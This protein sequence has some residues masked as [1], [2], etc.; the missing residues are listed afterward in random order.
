MRTTSSSPVPLP[1]RLFVAAVAVCGGAAI[2]RSAVVLLWG[3]VPIEWVLFS[4]LT[5]VCGTLSI[6]IPSIQSRH[7]LR[8]TTKSLPESR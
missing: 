1:A 8:P 5:I 6:K 7:K 3:A 4:A 2:V